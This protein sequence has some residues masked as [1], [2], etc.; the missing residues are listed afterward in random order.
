MGTPISNSMSEMYTLMRY[1]QADK[2]EEM[3]IN[4]FDRW[5]SVF[6]E[7]VS[8]MELSPEG[9][10]KYQM[11]TRFAKFQNLPELMN[12]FKET[13]DIKTAD[14]LNLDRPDFE[15]H[16]VNV[17]AT[18]IQA[19]MI[20][21]LG[22]RAKEIRSGNVDP[23][24]DNMCKLTVDGRKIGL[25]QR[26]INPNLPDDP[27]SKVNVCINNVFDIWQK[28]SAEK[29]T[30]LIFCDLAT[31]QPTLNENTYSVYRPNI[32][33]GYSKVFTAKLNE[34]DTAEKIMKK[35]NG[36]KPPKNYDAGEIA[37]GDII[38][39]KRINYEEEKAYNTAFEV[40]NG[41]L[42]EVS[43][44]TWEKLHHAPIENFA[45][46]RKYCVYDDIKQKLIAKGVP[47]KEIAFIHDVDKAEE[48][49]ALYD[50]M[51]KGEIRVLIGSTFKCGAG[52]NAQERMIALHDLD[53]P[54][55]PSDMEQRHGRIIRQGNTNSKVDIYRYTTD[56]TFDAYLYQMLENKQKFISQIMTDKSPVRSCEDVDEVALDYAEVKALC[57][58]NPNTTRGAYGKGRFY[59]I[60]KQSIKQSKP[61]IFY[62]IIGLVFLLD[63]KQPLF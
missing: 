52:M 16:N 23:T 11:K 1:L 5:A 41:K 44:E 39:L 61:Y 17:P 19:S 28:T 50:K 3:G 7:T 49:Q 34:K 51:N 37:D 46:E 62:R 35:L 21:E 58:G 55:R 53:A 33:N 59:V 13:A 47:E 29:S 30:Q 45:S 20:K 6:G 25:D 14:T 42:T 27:K 18:A 10:G 22:Q 12:I 38:M 9:N 24:E 43:P 40:V 57:A 56:K 54:M 31:P 8:S 4:S 26:C 15:M 32:D 60:F 36:S 63:L 48:K 2:L